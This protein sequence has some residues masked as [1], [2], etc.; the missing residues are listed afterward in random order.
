MPQAS[1]LQCS[2][3]CCA[4][5]TWQGLTRKGCVQAAT[6]PS[7]LT[8]GSN[9]HNTANTQSSARQA[10]R[11]YLE[12]LPCGP[13]GSHVLQDLTGSGW[14]TRCLP[15]QESYPR[16]SSYQLTAQRVKNPVLTIQ[17]LGTLDTGPVGF[18]GRFMHPRWP[19]AP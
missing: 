16:T 18:H 17:A 7:S 19:P 9:I 5:Y 2:N 15:K 12:I 14:Y 1:E 10:L 11:L 8:S 6:G 3:R 4:I 13:E